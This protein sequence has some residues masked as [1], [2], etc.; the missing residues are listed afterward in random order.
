MW[1]LFVDGGLT[2]QNMYLNADILAICN[3]IYHLFATSQ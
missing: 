3:Q 1:V 2:T